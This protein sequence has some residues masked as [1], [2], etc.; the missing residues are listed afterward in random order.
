MWI[1]NDEDL[2]YLN[3]GRLTGQTSEENFGKNCPL[4]WRMMGLKL[5]YVKVTWNT[6]SKLFRPLPILLIKIS[7]ATCVN[8]EINCSFVTIVPYGKFQLSLTMGAKHA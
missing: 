2:C 7:W 8:K 3:A 4:S 6:W 1:N 5:I